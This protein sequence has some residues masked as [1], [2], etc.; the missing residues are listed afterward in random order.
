M[1]RLCVVGAAGALGSACVRAG[2]EAGHELRALLR[3]PRPGLLPERAQVRLCD[4]RDATA[5]ARAADGCNALLYCVNAP[6]A[7]WNAELPRMLGSAI[8]ACTR[9]GAR[10]V[11]PGN[12]WVYGPCAPGMLIDERRPLT[13]SSRKGRLR[14]E[15]EQQ[16][17]ASH[18]A[19][20]IAR[21]PEFYGPNV[22]NP[23]LGGPF[24]AALAGKTITWL[25]GAL[26]ATVEY[27]FIEDAARAMLQL[28]LAEAVEGRTFHV[29]ASAHTTPRAF[30]KQLQGLA[31]N[32]K[33]V[34]GLPLVALRAA[35]LVSPPAR[36][37]LD[38]R[39][40]WTD[41]VLLDGARY[42]ERFRNIPATSYQA[43]LTQTLSW[44]REHPNA[45]NSN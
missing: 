24:R 2:V 40:L 44:F 45:I 9:S 15:L 4:A 26:D 21:L 37:F 39:H 11:F 23:L 5:L 43:G 33:G 36:E 18:A 3:T 34:R 38:I 41:P 12:V 1:A 35:A 27:I 25:G 29:P 16:I 19:H 8:E 10:L 14:A 31:G 20:V 6:L 22:A 32:A 28:A 42:R 30:F 7:R 17:A 13:P